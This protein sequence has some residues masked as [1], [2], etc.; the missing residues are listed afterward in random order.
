MFNAIIYGLIISGTIG[1]VLR[2][3]TKL[4][5]KK[6]AVITWGLLPPFLIAPLSIYFE[7]V[8][9]GVAGVANIDLFVSGIGAGMFLA[10]MW[11]I[12]GAIFSIFVW[13][14]PT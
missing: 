9:I 1:L 14:I 4:R 12:L 7:L 11:F 8:K 5:S 6:L 10:L 13:R 3:I 2:L